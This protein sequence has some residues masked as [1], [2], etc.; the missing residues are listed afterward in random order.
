MGEARGEGRPAPPV[1]GQMA[2]HSSLEDAGQ[3][4]ALGDKVPAIREAANEDQ[5]N[6]TQEANPLKPPAQP[7][8]HQF[9]PNR[10]FSGSHPRL[11]SK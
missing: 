5:P 11:V 9:Q 3:G 1:T 8:R 6:Q 10:V 2:S 7:Q 4:Q